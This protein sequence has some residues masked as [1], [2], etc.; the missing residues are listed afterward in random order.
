MLSFITIP[1]VIIGRIIE[2]GYPDP[3]TIVAMDG[4]ES[5]VVQ[6]DVSIKSN[7]RKITYLEK[8]QMI[9]LP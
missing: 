6:M 1:M 7:Y 2:D 3:S 4:P 5:P 8:Y 9:L